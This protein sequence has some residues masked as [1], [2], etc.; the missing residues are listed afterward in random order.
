MITYTR[1]TLFGRYFALE[2]AVPD[3]ASDGWGHIVSPDQ[4]R[5][6]AIEQ[7]IHTRV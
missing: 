3:T 7:Y 6:D 1:N 2:I 4:Q 5:I